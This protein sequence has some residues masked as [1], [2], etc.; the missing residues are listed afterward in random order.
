MTL[1]RAS[2]QGDLLDQVAEFC[3]SPLEGTV[4]GLLAREREQIFPD[5]MFADLFNLFGQDCNLNL[6]GT[7]VNFMSTK[8][9]DQFVFI[10]FT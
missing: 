2:G 3:G 4:Y 9:F 10:V 1:G 8:L 5:E 6:R 7:G